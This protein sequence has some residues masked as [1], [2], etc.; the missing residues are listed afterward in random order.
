M[1][2]DS[3]LTADDARSALNSVAAQ[4]ALVADRLITPWW[5]HPILGGLLGICLASC[6]THSI[7]LILTAEAV[8]F[9]GLAFLVR[10]YRRL[11]GVWVIGYRKGHA[12]RV[13]GA[14]IA[15]FVGLILVAVVLD[16]G[17]GFRWAFAGAGIVVVPVVV[18]L[19]HRFDD[20][21]RADLRSRHRWHGTSIY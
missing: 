7:P 3:E 12:G 9:V 8:Y 2:S 11:T 14:L 13:M 20:A 15:S 18:A 17:F 16:Y 5:Y 10:A 21:L 1:E 4:R 19:G 6:A